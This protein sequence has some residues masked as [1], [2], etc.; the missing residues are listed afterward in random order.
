MRRVGIT[1]SAMKLS[2]MNGSMFRLTPGGKG[3]L[4]GLLQ[5]AV[6]L[7]Q[8]LVAHDTSHRQRYLTGDGAVL[9]HHD[10]AV[11]RHH[12]IGG[13]GHILVVGAHHNDIVAV[14]ADGGGHR[15]VLQAVALDVAQTDMMGVLVPLDNGDLQDIVLRVDAVGIAA[16]AWW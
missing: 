15:A 7:Y 9:G 12:L 5:L 4:L 14:V 6:H 2:V 13:K 11:Q 8:R 3:L 10:A 16:V 1:G